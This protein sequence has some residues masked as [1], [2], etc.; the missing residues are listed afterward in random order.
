MGGSEVDQEVCKGEAQVAKNMAVILERPFSQQRKALKALRLTWHP[1]KNPER[2]EVATRVF[3]FIQATQVPD[4]QG[5][6]VLE[7]FPPL[8]DQYG[9]PKIACGWRLVDPSLA[10]RTALWT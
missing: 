4:V 8:C 7:R 2:S 9:L 10:N 1:D 6:A 5:S 3:Q